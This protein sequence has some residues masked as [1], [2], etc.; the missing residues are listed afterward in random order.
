MSFSVFILSLLAIRDKRPVAPDRPFDLVTSCQPVEPFRWNPFDSP[1][2]A[3]QLP[4]DGSGRVGVASEI[5]CF[6]NR[7]TEVLCIMKGP[8]AGFESL[9]QSKFR[10]STDSIDVAWA[11]TTCTG[12]GSESVW[13]LPA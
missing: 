13:E 8:E 4:A 1:A 9:R 2:G 3:G 10:C 7:L 11:L 6:Q 5:D 12:V